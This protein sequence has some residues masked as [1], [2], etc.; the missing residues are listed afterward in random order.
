MAAER[1][2]LRTRAAVAL[3]RGATTVLKLTGQRERVMALR[4]RRARA[5][6][7]AAGPDSPLV[8]P[9]LHGMDRRLAQILDREGGFFVEAGGNDGYTQS[10]TYWLERFRG[11]RGVLVEP[12][13]ELFELCRDE[14]PGATV[15]RAALVPADHQ[16]DT[17]RMRFAD[18]MSTVEGEHVDEW[19][20][21]MGNALGW[22]DPYEADVPAR[23]L[24][25]I[26][27]ELGAPEV[28]LLSLD[29]EGYEPSVLRGV[30]FDRHAPRWLL[31]EVHDVVTGRPPIDA[32]LGD[33]YVLDRTLSPVDLLYRRVDVAPV[34]AP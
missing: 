18:L 11:W 15:V 2:P 29:V 9:A 12:M 19:R 34:A 16:G 13:Q 27:D 10:N 3:V 28:D 23:T 26:L 7:L 20:T 24:S 6:R 30:D 33:R 1:L 31:V 21:E 17:V 25:S 22:R 4:V 5:K 8:W 32:I 14:R